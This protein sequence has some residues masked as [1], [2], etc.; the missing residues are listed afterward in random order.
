[1]ILGTLTSKLLQIWSLGN[2]FLPKFSF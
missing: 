1:M 2:K